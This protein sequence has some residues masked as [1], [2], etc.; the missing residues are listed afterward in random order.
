MLTQTKTTRRGFTL[1]ELLVTI[2]IIAILASLATWGSMRAYIRAQEFRIEQE[3]SQIAA[4][5]ES[6]KTK[7][8]FYPPDFHVGQF[9]TS[10]TFSIGAN[11]FLPYLNR[12]SPNHSELEVVQDEFGSSF[13]RI[14]IWWRDVGRRLGP[15]SA[16]AFWLS[17]IAKNKQ[18][19]LTYQIG[20]DL[21]NRKIVR[22]LPAYNAPTPNGV[23]NAYVALAERESF[24]EFKS[25]FAE[26]TVAGAP[27]VAID[28]TQNFA[29]ASQV[30]G[31]YEPIVY[32]EIGS[33]PPPL[34]TGT[35]NLQNSTNVPFESVFLA[36]GA[37]TVGPYWFVRKA[38]AVAPVTPA[39][40]NE[41]YAL[42][43]FQ[44]FSPGIDGIF[45][46]TAYTSGNKDFAGSDRFERDNTSNFAEGRLE[47]LTQ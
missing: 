1:I 30:R 3:N 13:R 40:I 33:L 4:A 27:P 43:K 19:P 23:P 15:E 38:A 32:F 6:F 5:L 12:I 44:L 46:N 37:V 14:D 7:Y 22:A 28:G 45:S 41:Y 39:D 47:K 20:I 16:I 18:Y 35:N 42:G 10:A 26:Q 36:E 31:D 8:G 24:Y 25:L 9:D 21:S 11:Q 34:Y 2:S 29:V 17:G